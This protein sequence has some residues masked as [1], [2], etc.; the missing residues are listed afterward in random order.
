MLEPMVVTPAQ[1]EFIDAH[2]AYVRAMRTVD[3]PTDEQ[4]A[5]FMAA[6]KAEREESEA[7]ERERQDNDR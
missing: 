4:A 5:R 3:G 7:E 6:I 2:K 1:R